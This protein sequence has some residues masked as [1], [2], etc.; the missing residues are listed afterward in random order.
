MFG[1]TKQRKRVNSLQLSW[2]HCF[3]IVIYAFTPLRMEMDVLPD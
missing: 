2:L 1:I 3:I